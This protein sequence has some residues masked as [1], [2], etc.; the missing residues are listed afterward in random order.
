MCDIHKNKNI[1]CNI[2]KPLITTLKISTALFILIKRH[3][4]NAMWAQSVLFKRIFISSV[5]YMVLTLK[6]KQHPLESAK[7]SR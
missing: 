6:Y 2:I 3:I 5:A 7:T 1:T 4:L